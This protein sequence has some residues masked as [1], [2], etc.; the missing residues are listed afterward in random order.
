VPVAP[1][2]QRTVGDEE[3]WQNAADENSN[4][5]RHTILVAED[6]EPMLMLLQSALAK[7]GYNVY[8]ARDGE[9]ALA[10][11]EAHKDVIDAILLDIGLPKLDGW[12]VIQRVKS[13]RPAVS[14]IITSGY[15]D[16]EFKTKL[17]E[18]GVKGFLDQPY[19]IEAVMKTLQ[20]ILEK[21]ARGKTIETKPSRAEIAPPTAGA[22]LQRA[23]GQ[24]P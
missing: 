19:T 12:D 18:T 8:L 15:V 24:V 16:P 22:P 21:S 4:G 23:D 2:E 20:Q 1:P 7:R 5:A 13:A 10:L 9:E 6:E 3:N 11:F 17:L 14:V